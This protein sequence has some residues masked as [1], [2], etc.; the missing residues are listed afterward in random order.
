M[1]SLRA[2]SLVALLFVPSVVLAAPMTFQG[3]VNELVGILD[4]ATFTL[5]IFG[6]VV[7]FWGIASGILHM[8]E[9]EKGEKKKALFFWGLIVIFVMVS[10]WGIIQLLQNTLFG[11]SATD[12]A[13]GTQ[14][15]LTCTEFNDC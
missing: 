11:G 12:P 9:D 10:I 1:R 15:T 13:A 2:F 7:Y 6:I 3:L 4:L 14:Q 8:G 5:I